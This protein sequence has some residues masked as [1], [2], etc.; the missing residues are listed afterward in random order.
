ME[1]LVELKQR[2]G[3]PQHCCP[4]IPLYRAIFSLLMIEIKKI[5]NRRLEP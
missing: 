2:I 1:Y 4:Q 5:R 3:I